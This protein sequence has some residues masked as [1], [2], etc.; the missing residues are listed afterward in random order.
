MIEILHS[1]EKHGA[2]EKFYVGSYTA[3]E[4]FYGVVQAYNQK[5]AL[6]SGFIFSCKR[7]FRAKA[8][9]IQCYY[10]GASFLR[11]TCRLMQEII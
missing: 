11:T 7:H 6:T 3:V 8:C 4:S 1:M 5:D 10:V 2:K 9:T